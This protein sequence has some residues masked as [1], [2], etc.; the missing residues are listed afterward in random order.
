[1]KI[2]RLDRS[3]H[4][5]TRELWEKVF[6]EDSQEFVDYYYYV[7]TK[8]NTIYV[9]EENHEI[10]AMFQLNPY[11][12]KLCGNI[13]SSDYIVGVAT[14]EEYRGRGYMRKLLI[15]ALEDQY[16]QKM[17]FTFLMPA[18]EAIYLPYDFRFIYR[19]KQMRVE[20]GFFEIRA[21]HLQKVQEK[22]T[23]RDARFMD[24]GKMAEFFESNFSHR[25]NTA[26][27][28][29]TQYYQTQI[30]EQQSELG[31]MR[32]VFEEENLI[33]MYAYARE[34]GLEIREPVYLKGREDEFLASVDLLRKKGEGVIIYGLMDELEKQEG[35]G[36]PEC[37]EQPVI[38]AR[39]VHLRELFSALRVPAESEVQCSFAVID[40]ILR[41]NSRI[42]KLR[43]E[44][45]EEI[46]HVSETEDSQGVISIA[47]LTELLFG[48][49][50]VEE[51]AAEEGVI[52][53]E[54]LQEEL[55]K[56]QNLCPVFL[57]EIV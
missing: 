30:L 14:L 3:E 44:K 26:S 19:Q 22:I 28:R 27:Q 12:I 33:G 52:L 40:P 37:K 13:V 31:G 10:R 8:D 49:R 4:E 50:T 6:S 20:D 11:Q 18:A 51:S 2:R 15:R 23:E 1:M 41:G 21:E 34:E 42:W 48:Y 24:A 45:G 55:K 35:E 43:S 29:T 53:P 57:N 16:S 7:K 9:T 32:L 38:M 25:W 39:I 17:P 5:K 36:L 47:S 54:K 56:L 46:I